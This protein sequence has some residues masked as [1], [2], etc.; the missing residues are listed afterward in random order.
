MI[1]VNMCAWV[2][3]VQGRY[4]ND[5]LLTSYNTQCTVNAIVGL[6]D[7]RHLQGPI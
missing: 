4:D 7:V 5:G 2:Q 3:L 1:S 6:C